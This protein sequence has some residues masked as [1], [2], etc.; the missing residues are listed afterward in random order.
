M[1][2]DIAFLSGGKRQGRNDAMAYVGT[3]EDEAGDKMSAE[4]NV[5]KHSSAS[6]TC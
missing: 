2:P 6:A 5:L 1:R 4:I 3:Y